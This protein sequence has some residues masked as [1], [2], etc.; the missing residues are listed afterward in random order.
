[1]Y[2]F[3]NGPAKINLNFLGNNFNTS[4][5]TPIFLSIK[6]ATKLKTIS[7]RLNFVNLFLR[8]YLFL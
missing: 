8:K 1:M 2:N 6:L 3:L 7:F 4:S 5:A